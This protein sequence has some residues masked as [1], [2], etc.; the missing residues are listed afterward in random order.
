MESSA[1]R[2]KERDWERGT[3]RE[4][5]REGCKER[6]IHNKTVFSNISHNTQ[7]KQNINYIYPFVLV[8]I[9]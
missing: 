4:R 3:E 6:N 1:A 2:R 8:K 5:K 7:S 9:T